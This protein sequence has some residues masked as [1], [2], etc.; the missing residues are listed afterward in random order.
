MYWLMRGLD[1]DPRF[2]FA[3]VVTGAHLEPRFGRTITEIQND[4]FKVAAEVLMNLTDDSAVGIAGSM[5][6]GLRGLT[7]ALETI[8]PDLVIL[9]GDRY[10]TLC[11]AQA[12]MLLNVPIGHI[13]GGELTEGA[14]DEAIRH[15]VTKMAHLHFTA[16]YAYR[17]RV[18][19]LGEAPDRVFNVGALGL[20]N[21]RKL[22]I[23]CRD[24]VAALLGIEPS[25]PYLLITY[26]P[27]TLD[28][29]LSGAGINALLKVLAS[30]TEM[31][32]V[33]TG[34]NADPGND[35]LRAMISAFKEANENRVTVHESLG[36]V[37]YLSA[38]SHAACCVGN[39]SSGLIEAPIMKTPTVN[40]GD[41]QK[42]RLRTSSIFD[43]IE[44]AADIR[45]ALDAALALNEANDLTAFETP[46]GDGTTTLQILNVIAKADLAK[47][48]KKTF[49]TILALPGE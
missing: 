7:Q 25:V 15:A 37:G 43:S 8:N 22:D 41:R 31:H 44:D 40:I 19:Q 42:G 10:E 46:Y 3:L 49:F 28:N 9:L 11:A 12:A 1:A 5:A 39:S 14:I 13:H 45:R 35:Q 48:K 4:G 2:D 36:R 34:V 30:D 23:L 38:L 18:I 24:Q 17:E 32:F 21:A 20:E 47:I 29:A 27:L 6:D 26:H 16:A 33:F